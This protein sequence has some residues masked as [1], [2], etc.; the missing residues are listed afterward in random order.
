MP[1]LVLH[2]ASYCA[3]TDQY[4]AWEVE[5]TDASGPLN[6]YLDEQIG[7]F[8]DRANERNDGDCLCED[9]TQDLYKYL[10]RNLLSSRL[11]KYVFESPDI[12]RFPDPSV[13]Y[14]EHYKMS[15]Y[16]GRSFPYLLPMARTMR[17]GDVYFGM[18]KIGHV[19]G[20]GRRYH[21][22][23][24]RLVRDGATSEEAME[25]V[26]RRGIAYEQTVVGKL[27]DGVFSHGDM[28]ANFQGM[29]M[30][31]DFCEGDAPY[32]GRSDGKWVLAR[33][34]DLREYITPDFDESYNPPFYWA[35][36]KRFVL[37]ILREEYGA[38]LQLPRVQARFAR[39]RER[40]PS[41]SKR[42]IDRFFDEKGRNPQRIQALA[43]LVVAPERN[44]KREG[45]DE[46]VPVRAEPDAE[47]RPPGKPQG[48]SL[49]LS[50][51]Q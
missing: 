16:R 22:R 21:G 45:R 34:L 26:I 43:T 29:R 14:S 38:K 15:I 42:F 13:S 8:L 30:A 28:E 35:A 2:G 17:I 12:E 44:A 19:F 31:R 40:E 25:K 49:A 7:L 48:D 33:P 4:L 20:F 51:K 41:F 11:R 36:R 47:E 5:L 46:A 1:L 27:V 18:D 9:L 6:R 39:Y 37:P 24:L 23:Y 50:I 32:F 3:E 10:F